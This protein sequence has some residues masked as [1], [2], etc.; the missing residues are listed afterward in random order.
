MPPNKF[1]PTGS[2]LAPIDHNQVE[3]VLLREA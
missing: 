1:T 3:D 2:I